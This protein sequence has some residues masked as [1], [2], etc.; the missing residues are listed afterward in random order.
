MAHLPYQMKSIAVSHRIQVS[1][2][3]DYVYVLD[4]G[5]IHE[6][7]KFTDLELYQCFMGAPSTYEMHQLYIQKAAMKHSSLRETVKVVRKNTLLR[8]TTLN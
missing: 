7:G 1:E 5:V 8:R 6:E 3:A 2:L 4:E